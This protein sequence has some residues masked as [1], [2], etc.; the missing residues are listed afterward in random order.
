ML[1]VSFAVLPPRSPFLHFDNP[2]GKSSL[3][4]T[5]FS[6]P[7]FSPTR[8][9][10]RYRKTDS[11]SRAR[12]RS[13][14]D[15]Y[16]SVEH[17]GRYSPRLPSMKARNPCH[18]LYLFTSRKR[19]RGGMCALSRAIGVAN[20]TKPGKERARA[21]SATG[22]HRRARDGNDER[23]WRDR[24]RL[25]GVLRRRNREFSPRRDE[26]RRLS[27]SPLA[28]TILA[29]S[30]IQGVLESHESIIRQRSVQIVRGSWQFAHRDTVVTHDATSIHRRD[31]ANVSGH[32]CLGR[33]F[34][35]Q[36]FQRS[37]EKEQKRNRKEKF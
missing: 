16:R 3:A 14:A 21:L 13:S 5:R 15:S 34:H 7:F 25:C 8:S 1:C 29:R 10:S 11:L 32:S 30:S 28:T 9:S 12:K 31:E 19:E 24:R 36:P 23:S 4:L 17:N 37:I 2:R 33:D 18:T 22:H 26:R 35:L 6:H 20:E 27:V